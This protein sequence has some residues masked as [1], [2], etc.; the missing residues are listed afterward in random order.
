[1]NEHIVIAYLSVFNVLG[2]YLQFEN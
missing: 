1:M 2:H